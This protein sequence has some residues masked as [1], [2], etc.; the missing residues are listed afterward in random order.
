MKHRVL[1][2]RDSTKAASFCSRLRSDGIK[3]NAIAPTETKRIEIESSFALDAEIEWI[4]F[5]SS[6]AVAEFHHLIATRKIAIRKN[7]R[8]AAIGK[9]TADKI[10]ELFKRVDFIGNGNGSAEFAE[11]L[12]GH[13]SGSK[14]ILFPCT[15]ITAGGLED[16]LRQAGMDMLRL[17]VYETIARN[18]EIL[19]GELIAGIPYHAIV[20]YAPSGVSA[21]LNAQPQLKRIPSVAIGKTTAIALHNAGVDHVTI[22]E[23]PEE[24]AVY[25][26]LLKS[27]NGALSA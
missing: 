26:A 15:A 11:A 24:P 1:L 6:K 7:I 12:T 22:S 10:E 3:V 2:V 23:N 19:S 9:A 16:K 25:A 5:T 27:L 21:I 14:K 18:A 13:L 17:P 8:F 4:V 20:Y